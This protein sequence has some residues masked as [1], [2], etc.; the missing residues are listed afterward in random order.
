MSSYMVG[1]WGEKM[2]RIIDAKYFELVEEVGIGV[3]GFWKDI[4]GVETDG[5]LVV[6]RG[7]LVVLVSTY[8]F[9]WKRG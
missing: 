4:G 1:G 8:V 6:S 3:E 2:F 7:R 9:G 5:A